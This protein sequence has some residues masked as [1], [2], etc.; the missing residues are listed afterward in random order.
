MKTWWII[1]ALLAAV[2]FAGAQTSPPPDLSDFT[3]GAGENRVD[4]VEDPFRVRAVTGTIST[5]TGD[6]GRANVL[7]EIE[8]PGDER[9]MRHVLTDR[10]GHFK[11]PHLPDGNYRFKATLYGFQS[12]IGTIIVSKHHPAANDIKIEMRT[13]A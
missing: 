12:V 10:N 8:G 7:F 13:G 3:K 1:G 5:A 2:L 11:I 6:A 4:T 9:T